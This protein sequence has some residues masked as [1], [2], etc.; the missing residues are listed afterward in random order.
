MC[1]RCRITV[2]KQ[3]GSTQS[4]STIIWTNNSIG[5]LPFCVQTW[6]SWTSCNM[7]FL[8]KA[9]FETFCQ[10]SSLVDLSVL[11]LET[12]SVSNNQQGMKDS[13]W[14]QSNI[15]NGCPNMFTW[16]GELTNYI[17]KKPVN[18]G[19]GCLEIDVNQCIWLLMEA[20]LQWTPLLSGVV[21]WSGFAT[22]DG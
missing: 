1:L 15:L 4:F 22:A 10:G 7:L 16:R 19:A 20:G 5:F 9:N 11:G 21:Q 17:S 3:H 12:S 18:V 8:R 13:T 6:K 2:C 14:D